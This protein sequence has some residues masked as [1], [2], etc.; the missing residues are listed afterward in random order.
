MSCQL[1]SINP[2]LEIHTEKRVQHVIWLRKVL[3]SS[4]K[5][6]LPWR[7]SQ[8]DGIF[9]PGGPTNALRNERFARRTSRLHTIYF[10]K[11]AERTKRVDTPEWMSNTTQNPKCQQTH[12]VFCCRL[13]AECRKKGE[14]KLAPIR[15]DTTN[16]VAGQLLVSHAVSH[17]T[18]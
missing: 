4:I 18:N 2:T 1:M 5:L 15:D 12:L 16:A 11:N 8:R 9:L 14:I 17:S 10:H 13:S 7:L 3:E 6:T